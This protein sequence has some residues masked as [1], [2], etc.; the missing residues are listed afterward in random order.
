MA[1]C[2]RARLGEDV[3]GH[4]RRGEVQRGHG[5]QR[6]SS[7]N[8]VKGR[9]SRPSRTPAPYSTIMRRTRGVAASPSAPS[10]A[11][12]HGGA[13]GKRPVADRA[14]GRRRRRSARPR[15]GTARG[16]AAARR[17]RSPWGTRN[18]IQCAH[19]SSLLAAADAVAGAREPR[20]RRSVGQLARARAPG[21]SRH[22][23][24]APAPGARA[25]RGRR[26][27]SRRRRCRRTSAARRCA[28]S[29][30]RRAAARH[31][32]GDGRRGGGGDHDGG[33]SRRRLR[34]SG[35]GGADRDGT[36]RGGANG[37]RTGARGGRVYPGGPDR[38]A[39]IGSAGSV[40]V[41]KPAVQRALHAGD[42]IRRPPH[43]RRRRSRRHGR[44]LPGASQLDLERPVALKLIAPRLARRRTSASASCAS[45]ARRGDRP[46]QRHPGLLGRRGRRALYLA[47]R[48]VEGEDLRTLRAR[49]RSRSSRTAAARDHRPG[50]RRARCRARARAR[51]PRRQARQRAARRGD[52]A[53]LTDFGL[54]KRVTS[55]DQLT[56][57]GSW[58]GT[59]GYIA[60]EQIRGLRIDARADVYALG[61]LLFYVLTGVP[62]YRRDTDEA[63]LLAH[64]QRPAARRRDR[65]PACPRACRACGPRAGQGPRRPLPVGR[66]PRPRRAGRRRRTAAPAPER[67]VARGAAAPGGAHETAVAARSAPT[68]P[69]ATRP[70]AAPAVAGALAAV[71]IAGLALLAA[72]VPRRG[73]LRG[74]RRRPRAR[75]ST[76]GPATRRGRPRPPAGR[77]QLVWPV[78]APGSAQR[79]P[80]LR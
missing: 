2:D 28:T 66:R 53:Y 20:C 10:C 48:F 60:P 47:M 39:R 45:R 34:T 51:P 73:R 49:A 5:S 27:A 33:G 72:L 78:A 19:T 38:A 58:V 14:R 18:H 42:E 56:D 15:A 29:R 3:R 65:V 67:I 71:P 54:T 17:R 40:A 16:G 55:R 80:R 70:L 57:A 52:H 35:T 32:Q 41:R 64:L 13:V 11:A 21:R 68:A 61:C 74:G 59:L 75:G 77:P 69:A 8:T 37:V 36:P 43:H 24:V 7:Q 1:P 23:V 31:A 76:T 6:I 12:Y 46:P 9:P 50:R 44:R 4:H 22:R 79:H 62:P 25:P 30:A 63:T 26:W